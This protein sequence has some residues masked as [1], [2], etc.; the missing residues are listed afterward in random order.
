MQQP[1]DEKESLKES[2]CGVMKNGTNSKSDK[3]MKS[4][5]S[6]KVK[7]VTFESDYTHHPH[8]YA[9]NEPYLKRRGRGAVYNHNSEKCS[10]HLGMPYV[11]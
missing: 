2:K 1:N 8:E 11:L 3:D 9:N 6:N 10:S 7:R 4:P 5:I